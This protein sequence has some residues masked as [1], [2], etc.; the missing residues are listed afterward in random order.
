MRNL[1]TAMAEVRVTWE[2]IVRRT[3]Y[4]TMPTE[5]ETITSGIEEVTG[6]TGHPGSRP[7]APTGVA[8]GESLSLDLVIRTR[9]Y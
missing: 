4:T 2:D 3:I 6:A 8:M 1:E 9:P 7:E 5:S